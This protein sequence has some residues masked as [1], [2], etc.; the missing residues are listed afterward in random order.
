MGNYILFVFVSVNV[1]VCLMM[2]HLS[3]IL[4]LYVLMEYYKGR[5]TIGSRGFRGELQDEGGQ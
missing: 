4:V 1:V 5:S 2:W 3:R